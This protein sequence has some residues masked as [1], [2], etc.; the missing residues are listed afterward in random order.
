MY[1]AFLSDSLSHEA[2]LDLG[3]HPGVHLNRDALLD[4]FEDPDRQVAGSGPDLE[5]DV[6]RLQE[7]LRRQERE[8]RSVR[9]G[10]SAEG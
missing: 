2:L 4:L 10:G 8:W 7:G 5:D 9:V 3:R 6:G 1:R